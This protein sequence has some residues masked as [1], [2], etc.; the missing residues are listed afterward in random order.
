M[1]E[2]NGEANGT[3]NGTPNG[4][5]LLRISDLKKHFRVG[6]RGAQLRAVDGITVDVRRGET[7]GLVGESG[8]GK[9]TLGRVLVR[10]YDPSGGEVVY[11]GEDIHKL[12]GGRSKAFQRKMQMIFQDPQA[13]L[14]PR[15]TVA[16]IVAEGIDIH[17]LASSKSERLERV[18][19]LLETVG[20]NRE[21]ASRF[22]HE[23]SGGQ[24]QRIGIARALAV[25][26]EFIVCDEPVSALDVSIQAQVI[27]LMRKLQRE[28]G[29]TYLFI[30]HDLSVVKHISDRVGVM[31]LGQLVELAGSEELYENPLHPYTQALLAAVPV[32]DPD[33]AHGEKIV[34]EGDVPSPVHPPSGCR[35]RTRCPRATPACSETV[36]EWTEVKPGHWVQACPCFI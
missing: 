18:Y 15:M 1:S 4:E 23:F 28:K 2:T 8:C 20:L 21:H 33:A 10:L 19:D 25:E 24:R 5:V 30:S 32:P 27:N 17:G 3:P 22:P 31:Y 13:S 12:R 6:R 14:N 16:D 26:P 9:S 7:L 35:F 34:L 29:L 11:S 36:P